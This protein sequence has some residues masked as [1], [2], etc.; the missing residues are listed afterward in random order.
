MTIKFWNLDWNLFV[1]AICLISSVFTEIF[2]R[3]IK[4]HPLLIN[5]SLSLIFYFIIAGL[6]NKF[7][8]INFYEDFWNIVQLIIITAIINVGYKG[9]TGGYDFLSSFV[10]ILPKRKKKIKRELNK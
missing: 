3:K 10:S 5:W 6:A 4:F 9:T 7:F 8:N 1:I 2:K